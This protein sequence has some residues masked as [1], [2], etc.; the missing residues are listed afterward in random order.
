MFKMNTHRTP[1]LLAFFSLA[2]LIAVVLHLELARAAIDHQA[3]PPQAADAAQS[4]PK[5]KATVPFSML[6]S[7]HMLVRAMINGKGPYRLIFDLGAPITLLSN[8]ASET[9]GVVK[10]D[11]PRSFLFS[12]RGE[13]EVAKLQVGDLTA[14]KL[15]VIVFD[16]PAPQGPGRS[17]QPAD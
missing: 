2:P 17:A 7:N 14:T 4:G 16:H 13:A 6:P 3:P 9:S 8:R 5:V 11:G 15:P 10:A 1:F 12:M